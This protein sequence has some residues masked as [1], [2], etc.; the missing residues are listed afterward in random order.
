MLKKR[1][2]EKEG[3]RPSLEEKRGNKNPDSPSPRQS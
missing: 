1:A 2:K 3:K